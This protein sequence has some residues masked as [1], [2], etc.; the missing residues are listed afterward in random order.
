MNVNSGQLPH[1][2]LTLD[3]EV[4]RATLSSPQLSLKFE[5]FCAAA[6]FAKYTSFIFSCHLIDAR[7]PCLD[8]GRLY[9]I[10]LTIEF[11]PTCQVIT[12]VPVA[13]LTLAFRIEVTTCHY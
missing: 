1:L 12:R 11:C 6:L 8:L 3:S 7:L 10:R 4:H 2:N 13:S 5:A 9:G